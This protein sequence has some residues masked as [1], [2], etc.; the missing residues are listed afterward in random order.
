MQCIDFRSLSQPN[1][2]QESEIPPLAQ[3]GYVRPDVSKSLGIGCVKS[4]EIG[5]VKSGNRVR[6]KSGD[7]VRE[8][9]GENCVK[10]A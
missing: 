2:R 1:Q 6:E 5:C 8:N 4:M 3:P 9:S 10:F 7:K